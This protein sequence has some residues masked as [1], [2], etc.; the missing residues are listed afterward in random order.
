M[1]KPMKKEELLDTLE[2]ML[3]RACADLF[4]HEPSQHAEPMEEKFRQAHKQIVDLIKK[5]VTEKFVENWTNIFDGFAQDGLI[6]D[7]DLVKQMLELAGYQIGAKITK[8]W[9]EEK[10]NK[11]WLLGTR[12]LDDEK[13][14]DFIRSLVEEIHGRK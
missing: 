11:L 7:I 10:A 6:I 2:T 5:E 14:Q 9:I 3:T 12:G 13:L 4:Q 1:N 8:E